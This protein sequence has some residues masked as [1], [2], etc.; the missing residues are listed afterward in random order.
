MDLRSLFLVS[1]I[2]NIESRRAFFRSRLDAL[3]IYFLAKP[4]H[5]FVVRKDASNNAE[6]ITLLDDG[7]KSEINK[8]Y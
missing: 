6:W 4:A 5:I 8:R 2:T 1:P 7:D 3:A